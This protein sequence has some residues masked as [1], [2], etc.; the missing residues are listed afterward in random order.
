[1]KRRGF[2]LIELLVVIAIIAILAS[3][4]FPV[5]A[6]AR[7]NARRSSCQSNLKQLGLGFMQ[8]TQDYDE[9]LPL[10]SHSATANNAV[11]G[12]IVRTAGS[13]NTVAGGYRPELGSIYPYTKSVQIYVCPSDT[14]GKNSGNSYSSNECLYSGVSSDQFYLGKSLAAIN[15]PSSMMLLSEEA[16]G[17]TAADPYPATTSTDDGFFTIGNPISSRHLSGLNLAYVDGHVKWSRPEKV[18]PSAFTGDATL[19]GC[20]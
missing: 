16:S 6:R 17:P 12:W 10:S 14:Q 3:I 20:P 4:L 1:M 2:T 8:Y 11:G 9:R 15:Q 18:S 5:F 19:T 13:A 7:E